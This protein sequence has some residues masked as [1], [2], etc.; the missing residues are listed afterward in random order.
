MRIG[1]ALTVTL[2]L[3]FRQIESADIAA[4]RDGT[5]NLVMR[6]MPTARLN[7]LICWPHVRPWE[8]SRPRPSLREIPDVAHVA[9]IFAEAAETRVAHP[10]I[11]RDQTTD[12]GSA[13]SDVTAVPAE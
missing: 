7:Y 6:L 9:Q 10:E 5:G 2:N 3:P 1:A 8:M 12:G 11:T 13:A 4:R